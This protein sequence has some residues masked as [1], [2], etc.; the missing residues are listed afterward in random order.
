MDKDLG[1]SE[2]E[3]PPQEEDEEDFPADLDFLDD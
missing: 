3:T 2:E 1:L